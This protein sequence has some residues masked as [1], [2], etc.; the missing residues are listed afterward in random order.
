MLAID[1]T[2]VAGNAWHVTARLWS[3]RIAPWLVAMAASCGPGSRIP[4]DTPE[5]DPCGAPDHPCTLAGVSA[6]ARS[7]TDELAQGVLA[8][9]SSAEDLG[10]AAE[11]LSSQDGVVSVATGPEAVRYRV[12]GGRG[13][14][15]F[16]GTAGTVAT[17][18]AP[19]FGLTRPAGSS[20]LE[21][22]PVGGA[23]TAALLPPTQGAA[24]S[25]LKKALLL[26]P[27]RWQW[28]IE[29]GND[30]MDEVAKT[31]RARDYEDVTLWTERLDPD[32][33]GQTT[34]EIGLAAFTTWN[35]YRYIHLLTHGGRACDKQG[36]CMTTLMT[37]WSEAMVSRARAGAEASGRAE[38]IELLDRVGVETARVR[39]EGVTPDQIPRPFRPQPLPP[40]PDPSEPE[41]IGSLTGKIMLLTPPFFR[42]TYKQ[43][44]DSSVV[45]LSACSSGYIADLMSAIQ[46]THTVVIGWNNKMSL[47]AAAAAG[48][49]VAKTLVEVDELIEDDSGLSV[50]QAMVRIRAKLWEIALN[51][52][53]P[54]TCDYTSDPDVQ[55]RCDL[56]SRAKVLSVINDALADPVT[57]ASLVLAGDST[58]RAREIVYLL[59]QAGREL[60]QGSAL[61]VIG[62]EGDGQADS[63][64]LR[65]RVDGLALEPDPRAIA[66]W[67]RFEEREI[68]VEEQL[69][70]VIADGV[71]ELEY[72]LPLGRDHEDGESITLEVIARFPDGRESRWEYKDLRLGGSYWAMNLS[73]VRSGSFAGRHATARSGPE[74]ISG[75]NLLSNAG[76]SR[77]LIA[78]TFGPRNP[79]TTTGTFTPAG[80]SI[81]LA[82]EK[83]GTPL[84]DGFCTR[85]RDPAYPPIPSVTI[86]A[87]TDEYVAG[88]VTGVMYRCDPGHKPAERSSVR[89]D[90]VAAVI[91]RPGTTGG[92]PCRN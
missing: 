73:G 28:E 47:R 59:D 51:P 18:G 26:S 12:R 60:I 82:M 11:W 89:I 54:G 55:A 23:V 81:G 78:I 40:P 10:R 30:G 43:G 66:L 67:I 6:E 31:L 92:P 8:Y 58:V 32:Y 62:A 75:I 24:G 70:Q 91:C 15:I 90:F 87:F 65:I 39:I 68:E 38:L 19:S 16:V 71:R 22:G 72:R 80:V 34:G 52:P 56:A 7:R 49:L 61:P 25:R 76:D 17:L 83:I 64:D 35:R 36:A 2:V 79:L 46:G 21:T 45:L 85:P 1:T 77:H 5:L 86:T 37:P 33:P 84:A 44:L 42:D 3:R 41:P 20:A 27:F 48:V 4:A 63:V 57:G 29:G 9:L 69:E 53:S 50:E 14:W 74:G 13:H 88:S